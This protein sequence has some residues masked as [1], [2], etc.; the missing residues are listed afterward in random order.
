MDL[1]TWKNAS[2]LHT[3]AISTIFHW[4]RQTEVLH[5]LVAVQRG[6]RQLCGLPPRARPAGWG[7]EHCTV[8]RHRQPGKPDTRRVSWR[9]PVTN[10]AALMI[11]PVNTAL[12][13][14]LWAGGA[15]GT[16]GRPV[17]GRQ[18]RQGGAVCVP[19]TAAH[20]QQTALEVHK[21]KAETDISLLISLNRL[22]VSV[23]LPHG[24][25]VFAS[26]E[27]S[28][29]SPALPVV[30]GGCER[31]RQPGEQPDWGQRHSWRRLPATLHSSP[32]TTVALWAAGH[33]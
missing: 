13:P 23:W 24:C 16:H 12:W 25:L 30:S 33:T 18:W 8:Q 31:R 21:G 11:S 7:H 27:R 29:G 20:P 26:A 19:L 5:L 9:K 1:G 14:Q 3:T 4:I 32:Q 6:H 15:V 2:K 22:R 28:T 10:D 17:S